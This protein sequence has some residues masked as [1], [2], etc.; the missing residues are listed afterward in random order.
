MIVLLGWLRYF[1]KDKDYGE[2]ILLLIEHIK[3]LPCN[4]LTEMS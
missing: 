2:A 1:F 3:I 4:I